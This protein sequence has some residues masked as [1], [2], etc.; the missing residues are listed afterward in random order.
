MQWTSWK[1]NETT[2]TKKAMISPK[3]QKQYYTM[4]MLCM[5]HGN[6]HPVPVFQA[7]S[8]FSVL[9]VGKVLR[10]KTVLNLIFRLSISLSFRYQRNASKK[11]NRGFTCIPQHKTPAAIRTCDCAFLL[12]IIRIWSECCAIIWCFRDAFE[13]SMKC[14]KQ[15]WSTIYLVID[16]NQ[17]QWMNRP[18][19]GNNENCSSLSFAIYL[20]R[21]AGHKC[22]NRV[23]PNYFYLRFSFR[24]VF[25][26]Q[27]FIPDQ[28]QYRWPAYRYIF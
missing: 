23:D 27:T 3:H 2:E 15:C 13:Y 28:L 25:V 18:S 14:Q 19:T 4:A 16:H 20:F 26:Y 8:I 10:K 5:C 21:F 11:K 24:Y 9:V 12:A 6:M 22:L 7:L 17:F 1:R